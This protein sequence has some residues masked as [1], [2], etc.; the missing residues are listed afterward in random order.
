[1]AKDKL[2]YLEDDYN[3]DGFYPD[4]SW[5]CDG[6]DEDNIYYPDFDFSDDIEPVI[7]QVP[8]SSGKK[9][10]DLGD[11]LPEYKKEKVDLRA[12]TTNRQNGRK[13]QA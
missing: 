5:V 13:K 11:R 2:Y 12:K 4:E 3:E 8:Q 9:R 6:T 10:I 1:M 7:V